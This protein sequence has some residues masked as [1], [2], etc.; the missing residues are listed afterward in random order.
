MAFINL[1]C[2]A[3]AADV[4]PWILAHTLEGA[5][6]LTAIGAILARVRYTRRLTVLD[7][8][9][10]MYGHVIVDIQNFAV[11]YETAKATDETLFH[12]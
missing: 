10:Q 4:G 9:R 2:L 7:D 3:Q 11:N 5:P 6:Q 12:R 1:T 8:F